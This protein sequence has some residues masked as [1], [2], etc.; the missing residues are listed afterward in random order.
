M[1]RQRLSPEGDTS[2]AAICLR[3]RLSAS[4]DAKALE[5]EHIEV[6]RG[7]PDRYAT[8]ELGDRMRIA[9]ALGLL[10]VS[11][12]AFASK[13]HYKYRLLKIVES[14]S[15]EPAQAKEICTARAKL[16]AAEAGERTMASSSQSRQMPKRESCVSRV[17]P[18]GTIRT[19]CEEQGN[20]WAAEVLGM[21]VDNSNAATAR[22]RVGTATLMQCLAEYGYKLQRK[23]IENC[24]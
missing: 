7:C 11:L 8:V 20:H 24:D 19:D 6:S 10:V 16:A 13:S 15:V 5:H 17:G 23:C 21:A 12:G 9:L 3:G 4:L 18:G 2:H 22:R 14:P 1:P